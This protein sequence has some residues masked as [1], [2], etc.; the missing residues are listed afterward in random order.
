MLEIIRH[1]R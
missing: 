1:R